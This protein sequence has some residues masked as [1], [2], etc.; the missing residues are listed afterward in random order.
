MERAASA[1][2]VCFCNWVQ[3]RLCQA[4]TVK[5]KQH[6]TLQPAQLMAVGPPS[7]WSP[8]SWRSV[9]L[10]ADVSRAASVDL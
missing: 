4:F 5:Q 1:G 6:V 9:R 7:D 8:G 3:V 10:S 2:Q